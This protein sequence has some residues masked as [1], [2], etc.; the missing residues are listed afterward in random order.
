L[1]AS[2]NEVVVEFT[3]CVV[4]IEFFGEDFFGR[5]IDSVFLLLALFNMDC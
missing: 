4:E 1:F 3:F 2:K 5:E